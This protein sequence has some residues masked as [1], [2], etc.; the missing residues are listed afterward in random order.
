MEDKVY[1]QVIV[2]KKNM[3]MALLLRNQMMSS[4]GELTAITQYIYQRFIVSGQFEEMARSLEMIADDE[5]QH[6]LLLGEVVVAYGGDPVYANSYG[7]YWNGSYVNYN[8]NIK[9]MLNNN[10][11]AEKEAIHNYE[12]VIAISDNQ[13]LNNLIESIIED[14]K[15]HIV[16]F[17]DLLNMI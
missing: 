3:K 4:A 1:P 16:I 2:D 11:R 8:K 9:S 14:E 17:E 5:M 10:I 13:S 7:N 15:S 6:F 12:G